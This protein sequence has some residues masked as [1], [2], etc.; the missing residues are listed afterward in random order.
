MSQILIRGFLVA[1]AATVLLAQV[2]GAPLLWAWE[3][4]LLALVLWQVREIP[5][6]DARPGV[7]LFPPR[8]P[9]ASRL[10]RSVVA[11]E[12]ATSDALSGHSGRGRRLRPILGRI[13]SHRL[14]RHGVRLDS[15]EALGFLDDRVW[16][17][18]T[19][20]DERPPRPADMRALL[21]D[22]EEL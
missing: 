13:A 14:A 9:A 19:E 6:G 10:P 15:P 20:H 3:A 7:P 4:L 1:V 16:R 8:A 11:A 22:L 18:L 2:R 17:W 12:V 5:G 21:T